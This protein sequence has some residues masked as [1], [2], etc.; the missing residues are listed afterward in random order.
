MGPVA[1]LTKKEEQLKGSWAQ[2]TLFLPIRGIILIATTRFAIVGYSTNDFSEEK[3]ILTSAQITTMCIA[4]SECVKTFSKELKEGA[5]IANQIAKRTEFNSTFSIIGNSTSL[6]N[7][8]QEQQ[9]TEM[10]QTQISNENQD[11]QG[12]TKIN[13]TAKMKELINE[14]TMTDEQKRQRNILSTDIL[15]NVNSKM[16]SNIILILA[17]DSEGNIHLLQPLASEGPSQYVSK[18][19]GLHKLRISKIVTLSSQ[20]FISSSLDG[21]IFFI[22]M[23]YQPW[24]IIRTIILP[25]DRNPAWASKS[26]VQQRFIIESNP[27]SQLETPYIS[28]NSQDENVGSRGNSS[29]N[30]SGKQI[31]F[32]SSS[33]F[34]KLALPSGEVIAEEEMKQAGFTDLVVNMDRNMI[35]AGTTRGIVNVYNIL[36]GSTISNLEGHGSPILRLFIDEQRQLLI[37][38]CVEKVIRLWSLRSYEL[39][40][41]IQDDQYYAPI[42]GFT[43]AAYYKRKNLLFTAGEQ[44]KMW[45]MDTRS[46]YNINKQEEK[47]AIKKMKEEDAI[48]QKLIQEEKER[49]KEKEKQEEEEEEMEKKSRELMQN[50]NY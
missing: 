1:L 47:E 12:S 8:Q 43:A 41:H 25:I 9:G 24:S 35:L 34:A 16:T 36:D 38:V 27:I 42:D 20:Q 40:H 32:S 3:R 19:I 21:R 15:D 13:R 49:K 23:Y 33:E 26:I 46:D 50:E 45:E 48:R 29:G 18:K 7:K 44:V 14:L 28:L 6:S 22:D 11:I 5:E 2:S 31:I 30:V 4:P 17:G 39:L 10:N 37:V